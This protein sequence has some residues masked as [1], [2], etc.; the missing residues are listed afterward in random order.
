MIMLRL[1]DII[2]H[3]ALVYNERSRNVCQMQW[4][5]VIIT[6]RRYLYRPGGHSKS[7]NDSFE[8]TTKTKSKVQYSGQS[9]SSHFIRH[10]FI[11]SWYRG[12][13]THVYV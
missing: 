7:T 2:H 5:R 3:S 10:L 9:L 4:K 1:I 11:H 12:C 8:M 13:V 6:P